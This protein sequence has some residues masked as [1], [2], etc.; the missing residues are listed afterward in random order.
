MNLNSSST[1][2]LCKQEKIEDCLVNEIVTLC[3][4]ENDL[5]SFFKTLQPVAATLCCVKNHR[6]A[7]LHVALKIV[8]FRVHYECIGH[9][10]QVHP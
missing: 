9:I 8:L 2:L 3:V 4:K 10:S 1:L 5:G 7:T 6:R